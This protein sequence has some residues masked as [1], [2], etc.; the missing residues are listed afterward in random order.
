[1]ISYDKE[2]LYASIDDAQIVDA[3]S[4]TS[5]LISFTDNNGNVV[6]EIDVKNHTFKLRGKVLEGD[7]EIIDAFSDW[8]RT[9]IIGAR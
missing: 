8:V 2:D 7:Q 9:Y 4:L 5:N 3:G 6:F 1:M